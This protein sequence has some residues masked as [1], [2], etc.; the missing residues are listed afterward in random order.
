MFRIGDKRF[1]DGLDEETGE[2]IEYLDTWYEELP[3]EMKIGGQTFK[4]DT[5]GI[6]P[7]P[8]YRVGPGGIPVGYSPKEDIPNTRKEKITYKS[9]RYN[10]RYERSTSGLID[11]IIDLAITEP[12]TFF[13]GVV[14]LFSL[15]FVIF[16]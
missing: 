4:K 5:F 15:V 11:Q 2:P 6:E 8:G 13:V 14:I 16:S 12:V 3:P 1:N 7:A 10:P 9:P